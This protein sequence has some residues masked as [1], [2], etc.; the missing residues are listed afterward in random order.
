M[1]HRFLFLKHGLVTENAPGLNGLGR[2]VPQLARVTLKFCK[3]SP[4]S[5]GVRNF[6]ETDIVEFARHH[7][8]VAVYLKPRRNRSPVLVAEYCESVQQ[9]FLLNTATFVFPL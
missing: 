7:P 9:F 8:H 1:S 2:F 6:I 5:S 4:S 3:E